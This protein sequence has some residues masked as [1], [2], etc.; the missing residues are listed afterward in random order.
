MGNKKAIYLNDEFNSRNQGNNVQCITYDSING[1]QFVADN[2]TVSLEEII[3]KDQDVLIAELSGNVSGNLNAIEQHIAEFKELS[4]NV[5]EAMDELSGHINQ[6]DELVSNITKQEEF[7]SGHLTEFNKLKTDVDTISGTLID[8]AD[9]IKIEELEVNINNI[10]GSLSGKVDSNQFSELKTNVTQQEE[11]ISGH[12]TAFDT[13]KTNVNTISGTLIDK[14]D[15]KDFSEL[16]TDVD[17]ISGTL[18]DDLIRKIQSLEK[19]ITVMID[20][21]PS[22]KVENDTTIVITPVNGGILSSEK[23]IIVYPTTTEKPVTLQGKSITVDGFTTTANDKKNAALTIKSTKDVSIENLKVDGSF[24]MD[25]NQ[26][27]IQ[28]G[29]TIKITQTN[30]DASGYNGVMIGQGDRSVLPSSIIIEDVDFNMTEGKLSNNTV[31]IFATAENA[32]IIIRNCNFGEASNPIRFGNSTNVS[33]VNVIIE[34]CHFV[35]WDVVPPWCGVILFEDFES[36]T[37]VQ[38][39]NPQ[40][41]GED[42][43]DYRKRVLPNLIE[44]EYVENRFGKDKITVT[45]KNCTYG[46]AK[47]PL[48]FDVE[49]YGSL[50]GTGNTDQIAMVSRR[51][52]YSSINA[53]YNEMFKDSDGNYKY[54]GG[55]SW[56]ACMFPYSNDVN[57]L[58]AIAVPSSITSGIMSGITLCNSDC[59]PTINFVNEDK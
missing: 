48:V 17:A 15:I 5:K 39:E 18:I 54:P 26:I 16:K 43:S 45:F 47:T 25:T 35:K 10:S 37:I 30:I 4:E 7:I 40:K 56:Y 9:I 6:Y 41:T 12:L 59:Y 57:Y 29:E 46:T 33:G 19:T 23:D 49:N 51:S 2:K 34:N 3:N 21:T 44:R 11:L 52:G 50:F 55:S 38:K 28:T 1:F 58:E 14:A 27:D 13:L 53:Y 22:G 20:N 42:K 24:T 8:K 31:N 32:E 36:W